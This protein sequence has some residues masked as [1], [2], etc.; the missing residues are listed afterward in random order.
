MGLAVFTFIRPYC[1][2]LFSLLAT[3]IN[4]R[5][6]PTIN[7][8]QHSISISL[9]PA[10]SK[11]TLRKFRQIIGRE[12]AEVELFSVMIRQTLTS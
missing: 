3:E 2:A 8:F 10:F 7:C 9:M 11:D 12:L 5:S 4:Q 1:D 6:L